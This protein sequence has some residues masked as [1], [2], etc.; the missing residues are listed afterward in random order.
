[1]AVTRSNPVTQEDTPRYSKALQKILHEQKLQEKLLRQASPHLRMLD[2]QRRIQQLIM[3]YQ[4]PLAQTIR[5]ETLHA[6]TLQAQALP[7]VDAL[8]RE[9]ARLLSPIDLDKLLTP[10]DLDWTYKATKALLPWELQID[11]IQSLIKDLF[12]WDV[13]QRQLVGPWPLVGPWRDE[14]TLHW[15]LWALREGDSDD[16]DA[17]CA[18]LARMIGRPR[19]RSEARIALQQRA[20]DWKMS[21]D[22]YWR[23]VLLPQALL[24]VFGSIAVPRRI[25]LAGN[26]QG[27]VLDE[28]GRW[29]PQVPADK[30]SKELLASFVF[31]EI[32]KAAIC[33]LTDQAYPKPS[34]ELWHA[35]SIERKDEQGTVE[36]VPRAVPLRPDEQNSTTVNSHICGPSPEVITILIADLQKL[37]NSAS[38][39]QRQVLEL[40]LQGYTVAETAAH[41][42]I[43]A[44][45]VSTHMTRLQAK[46]QAG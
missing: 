27:R 45:A 36:R 22:D 5:A 28:R 32:P 33:I 41:L 6:Q 14:Q 25:Q 4:P 35:P 34:N 11:P 3:P 21:P 23:R 20:R 31:D 38:A 16:Q 39:R 2:E 10:I 29:T 13:I 40:L 46:Y 18:Q 42:H 26:G 15:L 37:W 43:T 12:H 7:S 19:L 9:T 24:L 17:A 44:Q 8:A 30:L 1:M